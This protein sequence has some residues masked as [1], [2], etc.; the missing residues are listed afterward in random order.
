MINVIARRPHPTTDYLEIVMGTL[1]G[2]YATWI[3][4]KEDGG[5]HHGHYASGPAEALEDYNTR[6]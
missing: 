1:H 5:F 6:S 3:Y 4:N 2:Q